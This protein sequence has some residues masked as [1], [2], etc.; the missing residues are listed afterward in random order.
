MLERGRPRSRAMAAGR[1]RLAV[2]CEEGENV[3]G[4]CRGGCVGHGESV[5]ADQD[6]QR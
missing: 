6:A 5:H 4:L 2:P 1:Q 3:E